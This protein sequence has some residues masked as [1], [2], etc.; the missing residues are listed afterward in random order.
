MIL[1]TTVTFEK[2]DEMRLDRY[3]AEHF[4]TSTRTFCQAAIEAG[5]VLVNGRKCVTK[6]LKLHKGDSIIVLQLAEASE[7]RVQ[8]DDSV[9]I[10][11]VYEDA[12]LIA[13]NKPAGQPVHP[14][15]HTEVG[16][17]MN[18]L[19]ARYPELAAIG[20][21]PLMAGA[22]HRID[23]G[24]SGLVLVARTQAAFDHLRDQFAQ[25]TVDKV[26]YALVEGL[27][28]EPGKLVQELVHGPSSKCK[29]MDLE[30]WRVEH[31]KWREPARIFHAETFYKPIE[32][33]HACTLLEVLIRT[34]VTH[35]IRCQL[36]GAG[37]PIINDTW[38]GAKPRFNLN[39]YLLH[40]FSATITRQAEGSPKQTFTAPVNHKTWDLGQKDFK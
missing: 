31:G 9:D 17:L 16:T 37:H 18:G 40:A 1:H 3:L 23:T 25:Q 33:R 26:Y 35:Q 12:E 10:D 36:A 4:P 7:N 20:D 27:V 30:T 8:P 21:Q 15:S 28:K 39:R 11:V 38:Y 32:Q 2:P 13:V 34:G 22:L 5:N 14:L 19:V 24:T 6:S 29:M